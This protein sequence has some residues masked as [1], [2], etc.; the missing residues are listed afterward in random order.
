MQDKRTSGNGVPGVNL[1][2]AIYTRVSTADQ[3]REGYS[4]DEQ[5]RKCAAYIEREG[6]TLVDVFRE[7]GVSGSLEHRPELDRLIASTEG[8]DVVVV[9]SL[10]RLG[11]STKNLLELYDTFGGKDVALVFLREHLDTSTPVG[12][13]LRTILA[14]IAEFE[15]ELIIDRTTSAI[16]A[17]A[18]KGKPWG[19]PKYGYRKVED[20]QDWEPDPRERE[21]VQQIFK[22][23]VEEAMS[24]QGIARRLIADAVPTRTG[25]NWTATTIKKICQSRY[26]RG[27]F[28]HNGEL[29]KGR[30]EP[31]IDEDAWLQAQALAEIG[32]RFAPSTGGRRPNKHLFI[33]GHLRCTLCD[34]AMLPRSGSPDYYTCRTNK[35]LSG[36]G[37]CPMP[38]HPREEV[39][40]RFLALFEAT[41]LDLDATRKHVAAELSHR[42]REIEAQQG[43]AESELASLIAQQDQIERDYLVTRTLSAASYERFSARL[44]EQTEATRAQRDRLGTNAEEAR[45]A[46]ENMDAEEETLRRLAAIRDTVAAHARDAALSDD[47]V[48][49]RG[50]IAQAFDEVYLRLDGTIAGMTPG[51]G[52]RQVGGTVIPLPSSGEA[53]HISADMDLTGPIPHHPITRDLERHAIPLHIDV[54][55]SGVPE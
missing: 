21:I 45:A 7:E 23:R 25:G 5:E 27:Y 11:R 51:V 47:I 24:Y 22:Y 49:L 8:I 43:E 28:H 26:V 13:L 39:D 53:I 4:L 44:A 2:A 52:M 36:A 50:V 19:S 55:T 15:R 12:R 29:I 54:S 37:S 6:W 40:G 31:I 10:D 48:A 41:F 35:A 16:G 9:S 33:N 1:R 14:A 17:R 42:V 38:N 20:G 46:I 34:E 30:H 32:S 18:R 3:A